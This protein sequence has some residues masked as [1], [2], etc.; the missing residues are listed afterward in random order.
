MSNYSVIIQPEAEQD[1]DEAYAY[2]EGQKTGLGFQLLADI[3]EIL[4]L[5]ENNPLL[6][7]KIYH[8]NRRAI[9]R[10]FGYNIIYQ[11]IEEEVFII[12]IIHGSRNPKSWQKRNE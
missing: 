3:T 5:L 11:I 10:R 6:F 12:A 1:L 9:V 7:Q 8:E 2:L 4:E